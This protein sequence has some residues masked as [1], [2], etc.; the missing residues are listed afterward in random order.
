[1][2]EVK[3]TVVRELRLESVV[4]VR[5]GVRLGVRFGVRL[6][7]R[8]GLRLGVR[9]GATSSSDGAAGSTPVTW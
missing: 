5:L 7:V 9:L 8:L 1:M 4:R 6:G 3:A 2:S